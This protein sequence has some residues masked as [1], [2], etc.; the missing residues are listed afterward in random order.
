M[1]F[2]T[3]LGLELGLVK[4]AAAPKWMKGRA[5]KGLIGLGL[6]GLGAAGGGLATGRKRM[7]VAKMDTPRGQFSI[8]GEKRYIH[9]ISQAV[10]K[11]DPQKLW[12]ASKRVLV[13]SGPGGKTTT[14]SSQKTAMTPTTA[15]ALKASLLAATGAGALGAGVGYGVEKRK[16]FTVADTPIGV[17]GGRR[18]DI[19]QLGRAVNKG[20]IEAASKALSHTVPVHPAFSAALR[21]SQEKAAELV[22]ALKTAGLLKDV[23]GGVRSAG[24]AAVQGVKQ[25]TKPVGRSGNL[26]QDVRSGLSSVG[27]GTRE[28]V[29]QWTK[30]VGKARSA[31][32]SAATGAAEAA[33]PKAVSTAADVVGAGTDKKRGLA[34]PLALG[35]GIPVA[36]AT[37]LGGKAINAAG[38]IYSQPQTP[39]YMGT[40]HYS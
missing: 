3:A 39:S 33:T 7:T 10:E 14:A 40:L 9:D 21:Q 31:A 16:E 38:Q 13:L 26:V 37:Y 28:G 6:T 18:K 12:E 11:R 34:I 27:R 20:D 5:A 17:L 25:W 29:K 22:D 4:E 1:D 2:T 30:P 23:V 19:R 24:R 36:G 35:L 15:K 32:T 8:V